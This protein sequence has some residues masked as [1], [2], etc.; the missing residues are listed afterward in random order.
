MAS[1][2]AAIQALAQ[3]PENHLAALLSRSG[4]LAKALQ[5]KDV[6]EW[7]KR[8]THG[9]PAEIN[10]PDYRTAD[11]CVL[12]AWFPGNGWGQAPI[13]NDQ[14]EALSTFVLREPLADIE[15]IFNE[16]RRSG[17]HRMELPPDRVEEIKH[18]TRLDTR[19]A[20]AIPRENYQ[21]ILTAVRI[22]VREWTTRL[23]EA[24]LTSEG[25]NFSDEDR[26]RTRDISTRLPDILGHASAA[27]IAE[28]DELNAK[29]RK[30]LLS[31]LFS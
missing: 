20:L 3:N 2:V 6:A 21:R 1:G 17:G 16:T 7:V 31:R 30:G 11:Q 13:G 18:Q 4:L 12:V 8:E 23:D 15:L 5:Q 29:R 22:A 26:A 19:L 28:I 9:Y 14:T 10:P 24:G 25:L 27:A